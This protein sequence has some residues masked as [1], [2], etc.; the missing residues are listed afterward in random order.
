MWNLPRPGIEP[1]SPVLAGRFFT[2]KPPRK[3]PVLFA[4]GRGQPDLMWDTEKKS[5]QKEISPEIFTG[6]TDA[7]AEAPT[8]WPPDVKSQLI[9]CW[10][11]LRTGGEVGDREWD[12]WMASLTQW[13]W[14]W[15][16][17]GRWWRTGKPGV[18]QSMGSQRVRHDSDWTTIIW[19]N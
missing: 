11:K 8:L 9:G 19:F 1:M 12:D 4:K 18:L 5:I 13:T 17:C 6:G 3:F 10:K 2:T 15:A 14:I 16:G 7:E